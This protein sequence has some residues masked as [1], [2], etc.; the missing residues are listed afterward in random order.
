MLLVTGAAFAQQPQTVPFVDLDRYAGKWYEIA[1]F[2]NKIQA[3]CTADVTAEYKKHGDHEME[4]VNS[5]RKADGSM[6][7][8]T[9]LAH[10]T[11]TITNA[12]LKVSFAPAWVSWLPFVWT[13]YWVLA[14]A[15]DYSVAA[16]GDSGREYLWILSRTPH[17]PD[18]LYEEMVNQVTA[19]GYDTARLVKTKQ[20]Q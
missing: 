20:E 4:L 6:E 1:R 14:L 8:A 19:Q 9:G 15:P 3:L 10:V 11:D 13:N 7:Q 2:P 16:V 12:K 5:C 18:S 17:L